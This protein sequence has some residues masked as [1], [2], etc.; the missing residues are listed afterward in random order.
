MNADEPKRRYHA[1][2]RDQ[3]AQQTR[4]RIRA[5]ASDLF[6][7]GVREI[8]TLAGVSPRLVFLTF[9][10][11]AN[12]L[13]EI[14]STAI[15][16]DDLPVAVADRTAWRA[17]LDAPGPQIPALFAQI[18]VA[19]NQRTAALLEMAEAAAAGDAELSGLR[20]RARHRR[21]TDCHQVAAALRDKQ[22]L[23][24]DLSVEDA[25]DTLFAFG[26]HTVYLMLVRDR[27]WTPERFQAWLTERVAQALVHTSAQR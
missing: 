25:A 16:G 3:D 27:S 5:T 12:L 22:A 11:K 17:M 24:S 10:S 23:R 2:Q 15:V 6:G 26:A 14:V 18:C 7:C 9:G 20:D 19:I 4:R 8:A 1:P 21:H 13:S